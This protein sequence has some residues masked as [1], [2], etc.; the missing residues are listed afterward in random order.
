MVMADSM[1]PSSREV[2]LLQTLWISHEGLAGG[3]V[4]VTMGFSYREEGTIVIMP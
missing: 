4:V 1:V 3:A 2:G